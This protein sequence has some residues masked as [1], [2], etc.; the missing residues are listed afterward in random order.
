MKKND[1]LQH[2]RKSLALNKVT[3]TKSDFDFISMYGHPDPL[4]YEG[5]VN[6]YEVAFSRSIDAGDPIQAMNM[7]KIIIEFKHKLMIINHGK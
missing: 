5:K 3:I 2:I 1:F 4:N 7:L 6:S